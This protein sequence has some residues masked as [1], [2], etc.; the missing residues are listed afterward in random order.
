MIVDLERFLAME[1]PFWKE[2]EG[3]VT[4]LEKN[5]RTRLSLEEIRRFHYLYQRASS[6]LA[7]LASFPAQAG[8]R[9]YL[10][11][12]VARA[13]A[14][15]QESREKRHRLSP[16]K[17]FFQSFPQTFRRHAAAFFL[18]VLIMLAG[19]A[20][21]GM[22]LYFDPD[23]KKVL[24]PYSHLRTDPSERVE[25]EESMDR[26]RLEGR[27]TSFSAF[28]MTH[29]TKVSILTL[30]MGMTWGVGT[31]ILLFYNGI[32]LGAVSIDYVMAGEARFLAGWLLPHGAVEIPA[33]LI[34]GQA[35]L[36]LGRALIGRGT[37]EPVRARLRSISGDLVNLIVGC[38]VLL[39]WAGM[40]E[41]FLSQY[42]EPV[43]PYYLKILFGAAEIC[44]L[45]LFLARSGRKAH[46]DAR[47]KRKPV[48]LVN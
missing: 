45:T 38:A 30:S 3:V 41:S 37:T 26:D 19:A 20:F 43:I 22:A 21:G 31:I 10:E 1:E 13:Y 35:G 36:V 29:N 17:W 42:H 24:M 6:D 47:H 40:V 16:L 33:I 46:E 4:S 7:R 32:I 9:E 39:V 27:K 25:R 14:E 15:I 18:A 34:A 28:L 11:P 5:P 12:L 23:A 44:L 48:P 8:T 2:L